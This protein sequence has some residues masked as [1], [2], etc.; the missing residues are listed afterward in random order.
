MKRVL[1]TPTASPWQLKDISCCCIRCAI[2]VIFIVNAVVVLDAVV[3]DILCVVVAG[4]ERLWL[5]RVL[6]CCGCCWY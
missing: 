3:A 6:K 2:A 5:L 1:G 4:I